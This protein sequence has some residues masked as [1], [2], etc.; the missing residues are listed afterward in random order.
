MKK[1]IALVLATITALF[2]LAGCSQRNS[3]TVMTVNGS[4]VS[5]DEYMYWI[6]YATNQLDQYYSY[7]GSATDYTDSETT[8]IILKDAKKAIVEQHV[9]FAK[10][11]ELGLKADEEKVDEVISDYIK[12][13]CGED[14]TEEDF[15]EL[16]KDSYATVDTFKSMVRSNLLYTDIINKMY[17]ENGADISKEDVQAYAK[18][19]D[20]ITASHILLLTTDEEGNELSKK[21]Q[22]KLEK[23]ANGFVKELRAIDDDKKRLKRFNELKAEYCQ[24]TGKESFPDG[25]CFTTGTMV[26]AFDTAARALDKYEVSD[27][28]KSDYGFHVIIRLPLTGKDLCNSSDGYPVALSALIAEEKFNEQFDKW[29]ADAKTEFVGKYKNYDFSSLFGE[30]GFNYINYEDFSNPKSDKDK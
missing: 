26:E 5:W 22:A 23:Q 7:T 18:D 24:D 20:Y 14:G 4:E 6:G 29:V 2:C 21:E 8:D 30:D 3:D 16:I 28:V 12:Y 9:I 11:E 15:A 27:V 25:Y 17:G 1:I 13:Y 19:N 10:A